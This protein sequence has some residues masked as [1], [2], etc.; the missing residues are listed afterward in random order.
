M[1][2]LHT[3]FSYQITRAVAGRHAT[4]LAG[5]IDVAALDRF[6]QRLVDADEAINLLLDHGAG[7]VGES[8]PDLVRTA[9]GIKKDVP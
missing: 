9:L 6:V 4:R 3:I 2:D 7:P 1:S 5:D 8:L